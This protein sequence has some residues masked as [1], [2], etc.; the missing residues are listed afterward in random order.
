[1]CIREY[2]LLN[3]ANCPEKFETWSKLRAHVGSSHPRV[4]KC[5][6]CDKEF[7]LACRL[8]EHSKIHQRERIVFKCKECDRTFVKKSNLNSHFKS[9]HLKE[10]SFK[11]EFDGCDKAF[12]YKHSLKKHLKV[13]ESGYVPPVRKPTYGRKKISLVSRLTGINP[14]QKVEIATKA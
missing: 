5:S 7:T 8:K 3:A 11:C 14:C 4:F 6:D 1:M 2:C 13:H 9:F 10:K 12:A